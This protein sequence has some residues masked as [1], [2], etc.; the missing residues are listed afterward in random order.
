ALRRERSLCR[1]GR[2]VHR[3]DLHAGAVPDL[4]VGGRRLRRHDHRGAGPPDRR[5]PGRLSHRR[6]RVRDDGRGHARVGAAGVVLGAHPPPDLS[7]GARVTDRRLV[8][9]CLAL[10]ALA[11]AALVR[12]LPSFYESLLY[13]A[14]SWIA[15]ATSWSILSGYAGY[16]SFGHGAF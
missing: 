2:G 10:A 7:A 1:R 6:E 9:A 3:A 8:A 13:L 15:L 5:A 16:F 4:G 14:F 12:G 11:A